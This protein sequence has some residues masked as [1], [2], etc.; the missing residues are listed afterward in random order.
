M[1]RVCAGGATHP[2]TS[3]LQPLLL[4]V[5]QGLSGK[6]PDWYKEAPRLQEADE[7]GS[8]TTLPYWDG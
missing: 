7:K 2:L 1:T 8:R 6:R 4:R 3:L 5:P